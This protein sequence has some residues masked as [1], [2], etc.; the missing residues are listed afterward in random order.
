[1]KRWIPRNGVVQ[2]PPSEV[3]Q[4]LSNHQ[5]QDYSLHLLNTKENNQTQI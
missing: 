5:I 1:M 2:L 3:Q 4:I